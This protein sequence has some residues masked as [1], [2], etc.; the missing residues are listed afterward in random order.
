MERKPVVARASYKN[1]VRNER[2]LTEI[3]EM[4]GRGH[5]L[6]VDSGWREVCG[7][8]LTFIQRFVDP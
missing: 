2:H 7:T 4:P 1:Q 6:T 8:A 3:I 5:S